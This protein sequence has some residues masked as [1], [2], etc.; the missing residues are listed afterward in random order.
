MYGGRESIWG[1]KPCG[2]VGR[3]KDTA[4]GDGKAINPKLVFRD[5]QRAKTTSK[6]SEEKNSHYGYSV[7]NSVK[8]HRDFG[9]KSFW[10]EYRACYF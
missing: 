2:I 1:K 10:G 5:I 3:R 7:I 6:K 8:C 9:N 4:K